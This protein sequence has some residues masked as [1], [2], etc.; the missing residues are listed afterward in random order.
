MKLFRISH[1]DENIIAKYVVK[2]IFQTYWIL[3]KNLLA[4]LFFHVPFLIVQALIFIPFFSQQLKE[5]KSDK[6]VIAFLIF[7]TKTNSFNVESLRGHAVAKG[8]KDTID[9]I[10]REVGQRLYETCLRGNIPDANELLTK[11][12]IIRLKR[13][14]FAEGASSMPP[15]T[16]H[17]I[18][19]DHL[20]PVMNA[21][22]RCQL[23]NNHYDRVKV[24]M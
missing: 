22:R 15:I 12:D 10:Q 18:V 20:D 11:N 16:T 2:A 23:F 8:L 1:A 4:T 21:F 24:S 9:E 5:S 6:T 13:C 7:P 3:F 17:N 14:I 19:D